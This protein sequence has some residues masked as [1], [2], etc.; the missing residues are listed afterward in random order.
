MLAIHFLQNYAGNDITIS[1]HI[2]FL[3][4]LIQ[5]MEVHHGEL[6]EARSSASHGSQSAG[7]PGCSAGEKTHVHTCAH[8]H[9]HLFSGA[10]EDYQIPVLQE[11]LQP[12]WVEEL[13]VNY[14]V[15]MGQ[16]TDL[17]A[18]RQIHLYRV[19]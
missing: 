9:T 13:P 7:E 2:K 19:L 8:T 6:Q 5:S 1:G 11:A 4:I 3:N 16:D 17:D 14:D 18:L 10:K 12:G 15:Y